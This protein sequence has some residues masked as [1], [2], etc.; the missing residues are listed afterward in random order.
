MNT[1]VITY[2]SGDPKSDAAAMAGIF[3]YYVETSP[4]IFSNIT[5]T[6][7]S[8]EAKL[9]SLGAGD[10]YPFIV[11]EAGGT[12]VG[13]AYAHAWMPDP[14]YGRCLEATVYLDKDCRGMGMGS[15]L[16]ERLISACRQTDAHVL[17]AMITGGNEASV[18][19]ALKAGFRHVGTVH[20]SGYKFGRYYD[21][22]L[23]ELILD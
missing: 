22:L 14:V 16:L 8:M 10:R 11:A 7:E 2:R 9:C 4:V 5:H 6:A 17:V 1:D 19:M 13:Y 21:D 18:R 3:N 15:G 12:V 20:E 23:Y